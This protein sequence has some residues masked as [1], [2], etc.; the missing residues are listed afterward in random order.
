MAKIADALEKARKKEGEDR[1]KAAS[2]TPL[3]RRILPD[4]EQKEPRDEAVD[5]DQ[6][7]S[8]SAQAQQEY[9]SYM[10]PDALNIIHQAA[11]YEFSEQFRKLR[12]YLIHRPEKSAPPKTIMITSAEAGEGKTLTAANLAISI[13]MGMDEHVLLVDADLRC[14]KLHTFLGVQP[15]LGLADYLIRQDVEIKDILHPTPIDKL[16]LI[17]GGGGEPFS[18]AELLASDKMKRLIHEVKHRYNDRFVLFDTSPVQATT[19]PSLLAG[20]MDAI[21][22][23]V[24]RGTSSK[25]AIEESV[26]ILGREKV[27]GLVFNCADEKEL[28]RKYRH[29]YKYDYYKRS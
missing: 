1:R 27:R 29:K 24:R 18:P 8:F 16:T 17:P 11:N 3:P 13:A 12:T 2:V 23:V 15:D 26:E 6:Y 14:S 10:A 5:A 22:L 7:P 9:R 4:S 20:L 25:T 19:D 28:K 21:L